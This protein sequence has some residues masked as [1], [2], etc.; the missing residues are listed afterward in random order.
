[1]LRRCYHTGFFKTGKLALPICP[2]NQ[3]SQYQQSVWGNKV[4]EIQLKNKIISYENN[5]INKFSQNI[6]SFYDNKTIF[7]P[8]SHNTPIKTLLRSCRKI[9]SKKYT[10]YIDNLNITDNYGIYNDNECNR[11]KLYSLLQLCDSNSE[12]NVINSAILGILS[13]S[14]DSI[15]IANDYIK[16]SNKHLII[17]NYPEKVS[18]REI[19]R[20]RIV[21]T[22]LHYGHY[23]ILLDK[24]YDFE[25]EANIKYIP[26]IIK[27][28]N[29][30]YQLCISYNSSRSSTKCIE[31]INKYLDKLNLPLLLDITLK[32]KP[33]LE[34]LFYHQDTV[35]NFTSTY[36]QEFNSYNDFLKN[37]K[38]NGIC[39]LVKDVLDDEK[40]LHKLFERII[41]VD[42]KDDLLCANMIV[43]KDGIV[44]SSRI[45]NDSEILKYTD[46]LNF[47][48]PSTGG[49]GAHKCCSNIME[50]NETLNIHNWI[51]FC[52]SLNIELNDEF[53][54]GV[55]DETKRLFHN[56]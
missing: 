30:K 26:A 51:D 33:E 21:A 49:G 45:T 56:I 8:T 37:Y 5:E 53:I 39:I 32:P 38:K 18:Q 41:Y 19:E 35:L 50:I 1:M 3:V 55:K 23:P 13:N 44:G 6:S 46:F 29:K 43:R 28:N 54:I 10:D 31:N 48:H 25:G 11:N 27:E 40:N 9:Q 4:Q 36:E 12:K 22:A 17:S 34:T 24:E 2:S 7:L 20:C 42:K 47:I 16:V 14:A 52:K 15:Y